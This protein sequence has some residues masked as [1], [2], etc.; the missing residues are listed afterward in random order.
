MMGGQIEDGLLG[1]NQFEILKKFLVFGLT[2]FEIAA[3]L[4]K[5]ME[6]FVKEVK[7]FEHSYEIKISIYQCRII[8]KDKDQ[9]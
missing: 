3:L 8:L 6:D 4:S 9:R 5:Q 7:D 1:E 2:N